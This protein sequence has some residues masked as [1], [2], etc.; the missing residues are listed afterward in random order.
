MDTHCF[1]I[2]SFRFGFES[3]ERVVNWLEKSPLSTLTSDIIDLGCG[4]AAML[5]ELVCIHL[6]TSLFWRA[7]FVGYVLHNI[8][9]IACSFLILSAWGYWL[10]GRVGHSNVVVRVEICTRNLS[11]EI[12]LQNLSWQITDILWANL[13]GREAHSTLHTFSLLAVRMSNICRH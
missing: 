3:V 7:H 1:Y 10:W 8:L 5:L 6:I 2:L 12:C 11:V 13:L 9:V 4:N